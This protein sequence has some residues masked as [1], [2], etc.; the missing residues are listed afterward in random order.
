MEDLIA[1]T[2][3]ER[4]DVRYNAVIKLGELNNLSVAPILVNLLTDKEW[5]VR[6]VALGTL[7]KLRGQKF[8]SNDSFLLQK[9]FLCLLDEHSIV[10][11]RARDFVESL[12][13]DENFIIPQECL[14]LLGNLEDY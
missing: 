2:R 14:Y 3:S 1:E 12:L 10:Q 4:N 11:Q 6:S 13:Q 5:D 8:P 9:I 7:I